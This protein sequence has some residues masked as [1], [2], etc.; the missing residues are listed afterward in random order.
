GEGNAARH[1]AQ[2]ENLIQLA[3]NEINIIVGGGI[4][5]VNVKSIVQ[6]TNARW[7]HSAATIKDELPDIGELQKLLN[8]RTQ[9][10]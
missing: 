4:R 2:L 5:S 10:C 9:P 3:D 7:I 1:I 8:L 6:K